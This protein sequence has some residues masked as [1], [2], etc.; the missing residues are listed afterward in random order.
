MKDI[1]NHPDHYQ[2]NCLEVI[3]IIEDFDL[4]FLE[5]NVLK[6]LLRYKKKN[7]KEDLHKC[8]WYINRLING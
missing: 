6:Y 3:D 7:G 4:N 8:L 1:V 5:G 2:G